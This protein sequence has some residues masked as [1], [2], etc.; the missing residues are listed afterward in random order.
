MHP[1][2]WSISRLA[3]L[4]LSLSVALP[5]SVAAATSGPTEPCVP[6]TIWEDVTSGV[7]YLCIYDELYGRPR[8]DLL[9]DGQSG[10]EGFTS[11][12]STTGCA[13]DT[14][15][16]SGVSGGGGNAMVRSMRWPCLTYGDRSPEPPGE[17]R[18]RTVIQSYANGIWA[19]CRD[20]GYQYNNALTASLVGGIDMG[21]TPDCGPRY[22]RTWGFGQVYQGGAWR[23]SALYSPYLWLD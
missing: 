8:W 9:D 14:I 7:K 12:S 17:L 1:T 18:I 20:S 19:T 4:A 6:G 16:I 23:G 2:R 11:R 3:A 21:A 5:G 15:A 13:L 22:Y 10:S